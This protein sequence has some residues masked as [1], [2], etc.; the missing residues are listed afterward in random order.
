AAAFAGAAVVGINPTRRGEELASDIRHT[1]CD[2]IVTDVE[3]ARLL[4]G[5]DTGVEP[6]RVLRVDS[7]AYAE[8]IAPHSG[9]RIPSVP[10][11]DDPTTTLMLLFT[12]GSTGAPK[13]VICSTGRL[14]GIAMLNRYGIVRE[15][16]AYNAMPLFHGNA[17]M[18]CW[19]PVLPVGATFALR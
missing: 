16:V 12:A 4:E 14:A 17:I 18:A 9:A 8:L 2:L 11:A 15:D 19:A 13:A 3:G 5:L 7:A 6:E 1:D 10:A